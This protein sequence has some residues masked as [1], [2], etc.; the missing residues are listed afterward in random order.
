MKMEGTLRMGM[1]LDGVQQ[2]RMTVRCRYFRMMF[3]LF[4]NMYFTFDTSN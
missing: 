2:I 1:T 4:L 3:Y